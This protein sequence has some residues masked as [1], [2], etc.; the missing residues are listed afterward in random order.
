LGRDNPQSYNENEMAVS[1]NS[2]WSS[3][4]A[5]GL[6]RGVLFVSCLFGAFSLGFQGFIALLGSNPGP[7]SSPVIAGF[8]ALLSMAVWLLGCRFLVRWRYALPI[9][10]ILFL[11]AAIPTVR[12]GLIDIRR[13]EDE[14]RAFSELARYRVAVLDYCDYNNG[15]L[16]QYD[17]PN[18]LKKVEPSVPT[19]MVGD[20]GNEV[21]LNRQVAGHQ[22][23][24]LRANDVLIYQVRSEGSCWLVYSDG[25][26][27]PC[28][29]DQLPNLLN[30]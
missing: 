29:Q 11:A 3:K 9:G 4:V 30:L 24:G 25:H 14:S 26:M 15:K 18:G 20:P 10:G 13:S 23:A 12:S 17:G 16:P 28:S 21:F 8:W 5:R 2:I 27:A 19:P 6:V 1:R 7:R 22:L